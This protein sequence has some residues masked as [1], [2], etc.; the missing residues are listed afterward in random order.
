MSINIENIRV[1]IE[2]IE[3]GEVVKD[4]DCGI[5]QRKADKMQASLMDRTNLDK[6][7][8]YQSVSVKAPNE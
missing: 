3:A 7:H 6:Y 1:K 8:V 2:D 4:V 5:C